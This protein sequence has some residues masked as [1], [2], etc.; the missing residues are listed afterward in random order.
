M[1]GWVRIGTVHDVPLLEGRSVAVG[2]WTIAVFKLRD[3]SFAAIDAA[4]PH[5][6][7]PLADGIVAD[8]C[9]TCPLHNRRFDLAT[10]ESD[11][12]ERVEV[13]EVEVRG[14]ELWLKVAGAVPLAA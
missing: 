1:N 5:A 12:V 9:V 4:C 6:G 2:E 3:G 13:H 10:G 7:G 14:I 11:G 8:A